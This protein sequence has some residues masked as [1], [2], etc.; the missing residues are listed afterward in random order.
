MAKHNDMPEL[1]S[2][3]VFLTNLFIKEHF[4]T[5]RHHASQSSLQGPLQ[6]PLQQLSR[7]CFEKIQ[8]KV[9]KL[10]VTALDYLG[11]AAVLSGDSDMNGITVYGFRRNSARLKDELMSFAKNVHKLPA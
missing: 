1:N 5:P 11:F 8:W 2:A 7:Y 9:K 4:K 3:K 6:A 10:H